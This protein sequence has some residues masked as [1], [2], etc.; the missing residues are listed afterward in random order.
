MRR[1]VL[2]QEQTRKAKTRLGMLQHAEQISSQ[3]QP[4]LPIIRRP[5]LFVIWLQRLQ[6]KGVEGLR[7]RKLV[8]IAVD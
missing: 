6:M 1:S 8:S 5:S 7:R 3:R 4:N 2:E